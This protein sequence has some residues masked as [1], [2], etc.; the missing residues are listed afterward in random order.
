[1]R[2]MGVKK[3]R[4]QILDF[5]GDKEREVWDLYRSNF[6]GCFPKGR[7]MWD[8]RRGENLLDKMIG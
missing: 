5:W 4:K 3:Q 1:M 8:L 7:E 2:D 6:I